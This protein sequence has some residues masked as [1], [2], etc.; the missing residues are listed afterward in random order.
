MIAAIN[1][2]KARG[3]FLD[4]ALAGAFALT[5]SDEVTAIF[6][7]DVLESGTPFA[8]ARMAGASCAFGAFSST[9]TRQ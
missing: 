4:Y 5:M 3:I 1:D 2:L 7:L 6:D 8:D 9:L